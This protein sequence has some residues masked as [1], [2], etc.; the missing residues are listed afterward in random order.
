M[1]FRNPKPLGVEPKNAPANALGI[2]R[3]MFAST[4]STTSSPA[5]APGAPSWSARWRSTDPIPSPR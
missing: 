5:C 1:Q 3:I 2:R 4:T